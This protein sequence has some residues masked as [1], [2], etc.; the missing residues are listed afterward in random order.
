VP[1]SKRTGGHRYGVVRSFANPT[2]HL[3]SRGVGCAANGKCPGEPIPDAPVQLCGKH[4]REVYEFAQDLIAERWDDSVRGYVAELHNRFRPPRQV[5]RRLRPGFL[6]FIRLGDR[7][8]VGYTENV[9]R[10]L[11]GLPH[12]EL[13]GVIP[14]TLEDEKAWHALLADYRAAGREWYR[15]AP[16]VLTQI[17][18]VV[19]S[20]TA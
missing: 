15:A 18:R 9:D 4:L 17:R 5:I 8:K 19:E 12:E 13:L 14:G 16:E 6:Y 3:Q 1:K 20:A 10:R 11:T 7:I 2:A